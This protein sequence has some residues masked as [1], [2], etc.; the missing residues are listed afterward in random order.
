MS[1]ALDFVVRRDDLRQCAVEPGRASD[2]TVLDPG[3]VL[4][5]VD[6]FAFTANNVTY[7]AVGE[8]IGY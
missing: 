4:I 8:M 5:R 3:Q 7:G 2:D 6:R 1:D